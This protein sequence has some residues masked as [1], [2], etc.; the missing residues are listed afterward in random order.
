MTTR[1]PPLGPLVIDVDVDKLAAVL[2]ELAELAH[3][4]AAA[5]DTAASNLENIGGPERRPAPR[6]GCRGARTWPR[7]T[8]W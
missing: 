6:C 8:A 4:A 3:R 1:H 7:D 2:R 5:L